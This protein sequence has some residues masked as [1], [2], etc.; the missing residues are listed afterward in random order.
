[1]G[2]WAYASIEQMSGQAIDHRSDLY[3][4]GV[5]LFAML[6]GRRPYSAN[7]LAGYLEV[8][9]KQVIPSPRDVDP[10]IPAHLDE[11]CRRLLRKEPRDRYRSAQEIL[12]RLE[13]L[14]GERLA[15]PD[16]AEG[17]W[18]PPLVGRDDEDAR[19][20]GAVS[21]LTGGTGG[22]VLVEGPEGVGKSR[23]L[24]VVRDQAE[25][26]GLQRMG[27]RLPERD[28]PL[29][30]IL[31]VVDGCANELGDRMPASVARAVRAWGTPDAVHLTR[32]QLQEALVE[33]VAALA[34]D[35]PVVLSF[36][37]LHL[38]QPPTIEALEVLLRRLDDRPVL[39]VGTLRS[40]RAR[41]GR[42]LQLRDAA[43]ARLPLGP[44]PQ[45]AVRLIV[46]S[47]VGPGR[48]AQVLT[49][50]LYRETE[51]NV[52]F[53]VLFLQNLLASGMIARVSSARGPG[54]RLAA[55]PDEI[56]SGHVDVPPGV[57]QVVRARL[58]PLNAEQRGLAEVLAVHQG[59]V[60]L[61]VLLDVVEQ[62][63]DEV[64]PLL[65][66]LAERGIVRQSQAGTQV[67]IGFTHAKFSDVLYRELDDSR[68]AD[69]HRRCAI[70]LEARFASTPAATEMVGD[71]YRRAGDAGKAWRHL[72]AAARRMAERGLPAEALALVA[73]AEEVQ[74]G[75]R[76]DLSAEEY[77]VSAHTLTLVRAQVH[78]VQGDM[79]QART[80]ADE[81]LASLDSIPEEAALR[82]RIALGRVLRSIGD[83]DGAQTA[84]EAALPRARLL[85]MRDVVSEGLIVLAGVAWSRGDHDGCEAR[86]Q[87]GLLLA[88]GPH[89]TAQRAQLLL[90]LT[91]VQATRGQLASAVGGLSEAQ[92]LFKD[93]RMRPR[94]ALALANLAEVLLGQGDLNQAWSHATEAL[95]EARAAGY[96]VGEIAAHDV[97]GLAALVASATDVARREFQASLKLTKEFALPSDGLIS[98]MH[99]G[100]LALESNDPDEATRQLE[101]ALRRAEAGDPEHYG[102]LVRALI[103]QAY[104]RRALALSEA[105]HARAALVALAREACATAETA[106]AALPLMRK[107]QTTLD[108]ARARAILGDF[109][110]ALPLARAAAHLASMRGF[111]ILTL[112][113]LAVAGFVT[114]DEAERAR[115]ATEVADW[116]VD[117]IPHIPIA[118][119][120]GFRRR[121][122]LPADA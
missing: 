97:R 59:D 117:V 119:H 62:D 5:I 63:E 16:T 94:R 86:A 85:H 98:A 44:L 74:D 22:L 6:T 108:L 82:S 112:D 65:D 54:Y 100:R 42:L 49:E 48:T 99:L 58:A 11:I 43:T 17:G 105:T 37:D 39:V 95:E 9:R 103:A 52:L 28:S 88:T 33:G 53:V 36:D 102:P 20:R 56:A 81:A 7:D 69:L 90:A 47:L 15:E 1:V 45:V 68:R 87:E 34:E 18:T 122:G 3:S 113:S 77:A 107:A 115:L 78:E 121:L 13:K 60:D 75:A 118:W 104:G 25:A 72:I 12:Y 23:L 76:V 84:V 80:A 92:L 24:D 21:A 29:G 116:V 110:G 2:T 32:E 4:L 38:A 73:R 106:L 51:G 91:S 120:D 71:H 79:A 50:R 10:E 101:D 64:S 61:D 70:A 67:V 111:R 27:E 14:G 114:S 40:D 93:L 26:M 89:F 30:P 46:E 35:G 109:E 83:L 66:A 57:R 8:Q 41:S 96:P 19:L 31:R 55:D